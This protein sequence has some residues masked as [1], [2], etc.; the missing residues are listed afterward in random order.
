MGE[1]ETDRACALEWER[2]SRYRVHE[3]RGTI[4][5]GGDRND[6]DILHR[7]PLRDT[8]M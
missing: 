7:A 5:F 4:M 1:G 6:V 8:H 2:K 3:S